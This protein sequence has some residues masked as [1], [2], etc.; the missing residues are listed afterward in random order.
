MFRLGRKEGFQLS[1][2]EVLI[3]LDW[4]NSQYQVVISHSLNKSHLRNKLYNRRKTLTLILNKEQLVQQHKL[5][6]RFMKWCLLLVKTKNCMNKL[7]SQ[8]F[9]WTSIYRW[10]KV[11]NLSIIILKTSL[12]LWLIRATLAAHM[13]SS[14]L[15]ILLILDF[16]NHH[17]NYL[18]FPTMI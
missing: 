9:R 5:L 6:P 16:R 11:Q 18:R 14:S 8:L 13:L 1:N 2:L 10:S 12:F 17:K 15:T 3:L 4:G 7:G